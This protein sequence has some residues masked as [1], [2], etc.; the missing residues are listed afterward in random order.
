MPSC[1]DKLPCG[2]HITIIVWV[3]GVII[4]AMTTLAYGVIDNRNRTI[5]EERALSKN[6]SDA[7]VVAAHQH[8]E[9]MQRTMVHIDIVKS[10]IIQRLSRIEAKMP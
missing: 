6:L 10:D 4:T 8:D 7:Q 5:D 9:M 1:N 3:A 2:Q